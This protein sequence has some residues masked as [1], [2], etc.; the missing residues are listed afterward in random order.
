MAVAATNGMPNSVIRKP[1][2]TLVFGEK[3]ADHHHYM[4]LVQ[5]MGNDMDRIA[6]DRHS[7]GASGKPGAGGANFAY[8]DGGARYVRAF[9]SIY[10]INQW[11]VMEIWRTNVAYTGSGG[12]D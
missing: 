7:R 8:A 1:T 5:D 6:H 11:A 10:P 2:D 4:D 9:R 3:T 12:T